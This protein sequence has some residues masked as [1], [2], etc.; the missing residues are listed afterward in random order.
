MDVENA[1]LAQRQMVRQLASFET[2]NLW[3]LKETKCSRQAQNPL[4]VEQG[5]HEI[6]VRP[7]NTMVMPHCTIIS[8]EKSGFDD[9][10]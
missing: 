9:F 1:S 6:S 10:S 2:D 8:I 4:G 5:H 3:Q 7:Y